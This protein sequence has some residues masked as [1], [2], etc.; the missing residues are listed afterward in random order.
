MQETA[1]PYSE[2]EVRDSFS[3]MATILTLK[4]ELERRLQKQGMAVSGRGKSRAKV[5][6]LERARHVQGSQRMPVQLRHRS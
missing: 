6:R 3:E 2:N 1:K 4:D 5:L